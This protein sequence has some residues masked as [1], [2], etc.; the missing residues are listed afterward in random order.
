MTEGK[1]LIGTASF[2]WS[3]G[4]GPNRYL[5]LWQ[6]FVLPQEND[7]PVC[8]CISADSR[9]AVWVNG[10]YVPAWQ[11]ADYPEYKVFDEIDISSLVRPG[12]NRLAVLGYFQGED[13]SV[14]RLGRAGVCFAVAA[15]DTPVALSG[16]RTLCRE[17]RTYRSGEVER[18]TG[19]LSFS[20]RY[21]AAQDDGW[22][23]DGY[24]PGADWHPAQPTGY[25]PQ[26]FPRPIRQLELMPVRPAVPV[27]Q[28]SLIHI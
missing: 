17:T 15:G 18:I 4:E 8:L 21:D 25:A 19:Q 2:V 1:R 5:D 23:D 22:R 13:S 24:R 16:E 27:A 6:T 7:R 20:F 14:Y 26:L 28:L 11:Y 12:E 3:G 9:Y 10:T